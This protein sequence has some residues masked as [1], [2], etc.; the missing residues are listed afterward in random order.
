LC[1]SPSVPLARQPANH[2]E[3]MFDVYRG[4]RVLVTGHTGFKGA[5]LAEWLKRE[6]A[7]VGGLALPPE[8]PAASLFAAA[9]VASEMDSEFGDIRELSTVRGFVERFRPEIIFHLAAQALVRRSYRAPVDTFATNVMGTVHV[10]EAARLDPGVRA[11]VCVTTDKVYANRSWVWGYRESDELGGRDP[12]SASKAGAELAAAAY[13]ATLMPLAGGAAVATARG[14]N[15]IGGGDWAED[16][17]IPDIVRAIVEERQIV[18]RNP[19]AVR[20]WQHVLELCRGYLRLG[21]ALLR[22]PQSAAGAWNFGPSRESEVEVGRLVSDFCRT[23]DSAPAIREEHST[24]EEEMTLR[25]DHGKALHSLGWRPLLSYEQ[26][27]AMTAEWYR[28][29]HVLGRTARRLVDDQ[30][31]RYLALAAA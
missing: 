30:L 29:F 5:W 8:D 17:L 15:V 10:L 25:L 27:V 9:G 12:Y 28:S 24:L 18:L 14:G 23:W 19:R 11:V 7:V 26:N 6:G 1:L 2:E 31:E 16:R 21:E 4:L 20:P 3:A 13:A 22:D